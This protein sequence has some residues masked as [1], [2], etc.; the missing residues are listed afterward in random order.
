MDVAARYQVSKALTAY[1]R[2]ENLFD[3]DIVEE[4]GYKEPGAYGIVG[5]EYRFF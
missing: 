1:A 2:V 4:V 5:L 3:R